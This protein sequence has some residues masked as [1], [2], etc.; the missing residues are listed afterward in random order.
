MICDLINLENGMR[1]GVSITAASVR[2]P[3]VPTGFF[4]K[5]DTREEIMM[6]LIVSLVALLGALLFALARQLQVRKLEQDLRDKLPPSNRLSWRSGSKHSLQAWVEINTDSPP[7]PEA[8]GT[9]NTSFDLRNTPAATKEY[10]IAKVSVVASG[11]DGLI[12]ALPDFAKFSHLDTETIHRISE[13]VIDFV[14]GFDSFGVFIGQNLILA[15]EHGQD[16]WLISITVFLAKQLVGIAI[17]NGPMLHGIIQPVTHELASLLS[18][19]P[20]LNLDVLHEALLHGGLIAGAH[21]PIFTVLFSSY[22]ELRLLLDDKT[23][24]Y[25]VLI[26]IAVDAG[27]VSIGAIVG[28]KLGVIAATK[29]GALIGLT[30][31]PIGAGAGAVTGAIIAAILAKV[32]ASKIRTARFEAALKEY[33]EA[34]PE[35]N[36]EVQRRIDLAK[37]DLD[38]LKQECD[39]AFQKDRE[40]ILSR[41]QEDLEEAKTQYNTSVESM[42]IAFPS[43]LDE[44][45]AGLRMERLVVGRQLRPTRLSKLWPT[46]T[47]IMRTLVDDWF[48]TAETFVRSELDAYSRMSK[49][50]LKERLTKIQGFLSEYSFTLHSLEA[51]VRQVVKSGQRADVLRDTSVQELELSRRVLV[52]QFTNELAKATCAITRLSDDMKTKVDHLFSKLKAEADAAGIQLPESS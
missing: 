29:G 47:D 6:L 22:R 5:P 17:D 28:T 19:M 51:D 1:L 50:P 16:A 36:A 46:K 20:H 13:Q 38:H 14:A 7:V 8:C 39:R 25:R 42:A 43:R 41:L 18:K 33:L 49:E 12:E 40:R 48:Q 2:P 34:V 32:G 35:A 23:S 11:T 31:G 30:V 10:W 27:T 15:A 44:L 52:S 21:L 9:M 4:S 26:N 37:A 3:A 24:P 45:L